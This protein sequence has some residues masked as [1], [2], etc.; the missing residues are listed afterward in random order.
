MW[1]TRLFK[2][3]YVGFS[4]ILVVLRFLKPPPQ[5][6]S[7]PQMIHRYE[8]V[9]IEILFYK[10]VVWVTIIVSRCV[11]HSSIIKFGKISERHCFACLFV[12]MIVVCLWWQYFISN[13][14]TGLVTHLLPEPQD[15]L[16]I[17]IRIYFEFWIV[18]KGNERSVLTIATEGNATRKKPVTSI[19]LYRTR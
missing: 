5:Q 19:A 15:N 18:K 2:L 17:Y 6:R 8:S 14:P 13:I 3:P 11:T 1:R 16:Y 10:G 9:F 12:C 7:V 4:K